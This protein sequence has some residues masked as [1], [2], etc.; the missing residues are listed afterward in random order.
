[1]DYTITKITFDKKTKSANVFFDTKVTLNISPELVAKFNLKCGVVLNQGL[2]NQ[3]CY[4]QEVIQAKSIA[5]RYISYRP[6][7]TWEVKFKL[8]NLR[9]SPSAVERTIDVLKELGY[10]DDKCFAEKYINEKL[11][12]KKSSFIKIE[13][14]LLRKGIAK[15]IIENVFGR[16]DRLDFEK[17]NALKHAQKKYHSVRVESELERKQKTINYLIRKGF[18]FELA[19]EV[20]E[21]VAKEHNSAHPEGLEPPTL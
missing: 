7:T 18:P 5:I 3:I 13:Q 17:F 21:V 15:D 14:E 10:L 2:F 9:F 11:R 20:V 1:M 6:R 16:Y 4:E 19:N 8:S 12:L